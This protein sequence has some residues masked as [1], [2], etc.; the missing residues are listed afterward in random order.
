[1]KGDGSGRELGSCLVRKGE[2]SDGG[3]RRA[4]EEENVNT[5]K[6]RNARINQGTEGEEVKR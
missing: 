6:R 4:N 3:G 1:M 2:M 5:G